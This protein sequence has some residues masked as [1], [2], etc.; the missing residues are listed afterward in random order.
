MIINMNGAKAPETPS[1][2]LQEKTVTPETLPT[3]IGP[4]AGYDGLSQVTVNPDA[5]LKAENIR[6]GK[7]IFG[8]TGSFVGVNTGDALSP[9]ELAKY[10]DCYQDVGY[11]LIYPKDYKLIYTPDAKPDTSAGYIISAGVNCNAV[12]YITRWTTPLEVKRSYGMCK[13]NLIKN[14]SSTTNFTSSS[15]TGKVSG[16]FAKEY[17]GNPIYYSNALD[18]ILRFAGMSDGVYEYNLHI[19]GIFTI[20]SS[21]Y[22]ISNY[23]KSTEWDPIEFEGDITVKYRNGNSSNTTG[24]IDITGLPNVEVTNVTVGYPYSTVKSDQYLVFIIRDLYF[25][26]L[27]T[28]VE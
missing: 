21:L 13:S 7:T 10:V 1:S 2:V 27:P 22:T 26:D 15:N 17:T 20:I 28:K 5:Q 16:S 25:N 14:T 18:E 3:V 4:D 11:A 8:V 24:V 9:S 12:T 23:I 19:K 6:S